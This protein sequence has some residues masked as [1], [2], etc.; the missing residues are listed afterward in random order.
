MSS[1][2]FVQSWDFCEVL[3][4]SPARNWCVVINHLKSKYKAK[5]ILPIFVWLVALS[6]AK[7]E[8]E[9]QAGCIIRMCDSKQ[10]NRSP[11]ANPGALLRMQNEGQFLWNDAAIHQNTE[12][13]I[14]LNVEWAL[15]SFQCV[16]VHTNQWNTVSHQFKTVHIH[17]QNNNK[18]YKHFKIPSHTHT[19]TLRINNQ[20][21]YWSG[22]EI[23]EFICLCFAT[24][25]TT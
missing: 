16:L 5:H 20:L 13:I 21:V 18:P 15:L 3:N 25:G 14:M 2:V 7:V 1:T 19:H 12:I 17:L 11:A 6:N 10:L 8:F 9:M 24:R 4:K 22:S 23:G